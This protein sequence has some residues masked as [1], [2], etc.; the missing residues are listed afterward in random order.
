VIQ[1]HNGKKGDYPRYNGFFPQG[2]KGAMDRGEPMVGDL[3]M[4]AFFHFCSAE[5]FTSQYSL[6]FRCMQVFGTLVYVYA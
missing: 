6:N 3:E 2:K 1:P 5:V 4:L